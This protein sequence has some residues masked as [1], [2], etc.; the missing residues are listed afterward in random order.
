MGE[1]IAVLSGKGGTGKTSVCAGVA[2]ALAQAGEKVL[3]IDCDVGLRN[4]DISL[5]IS[6]LGTLSFLDVCQGGYSLDQAAA[7]PVFPN[8]HFLTAP[9][10]CPVDKIDLAAFNSMLQ[11]ARRQ[12][13]YVLLDAPAGID[14]GF[15]LAAK[16]ADRVI[17]VTGGDPASIRDATRAG[18]ILE[19]MGK[20]NIRLVVNRINQ[21]MFSAMALTVDD[22]MD[23]AGLPLL[24]VVPEDQNVV[25]AAAFR[26]PLLGYT[27]KGAAKACRRIA[28]RIQGIS[29]PIPQKI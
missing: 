15:N 27:R 29:T 18:E 26:Q 14:A 8:L 5:G 4:L 7:H 21:K 13:S 25:L 16:F 9:I 10:N 20:R 3:C 12:F 28:K 2:S 17:L 11:Q 1:L 23:R 22:V 19:L 6:E 24:G